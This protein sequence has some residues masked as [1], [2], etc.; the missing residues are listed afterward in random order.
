MATNRSRPHDI[1][2]RLLAGV[3]PDARR[4]IV[5]G[6]RRRTLRPAQILFRTGEPA[7]QL[8]LLRKGRVQFTRLARTGREIV[9]GILVPGDVFGLGSILTEHIDYMGTAESL[10]TGEVLV[11][12][13]ERIQAFADEHP[14][15]SENA[16]HVAL[17]YVA[18]FAERHER[19]VTVSAEQRL[20]RALTRLGVRTGTRKR[21]GVEV[22]IKNE[23]LASLADV[24]PF[25]ASRLLKRWER[26]GM[27]GKSRGIVRI[28]C[29]EKLLVD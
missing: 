6:S 2:D 4:V 17:R 16:L 11:W 10:E 8:F 23:Q 1:T 24:S 9:M 3:A 18:L 13:R 25:T 27:I 5:A 19:L 26:D 28:I 29:P 22:H 21:S 14:Q 15:V 20:A 7:E 12:T